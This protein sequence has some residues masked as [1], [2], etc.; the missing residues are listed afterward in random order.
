MLESAAT[1]RYLN[2]VVEEQDEER[3]DGWTYGSEP[4]IIFRTDRGR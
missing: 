2:L 1:E 3:D 4:P